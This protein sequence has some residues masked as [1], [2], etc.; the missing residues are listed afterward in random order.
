MH[1]P[2]IPMID[3][4]LVL[5]QREGAHLLA[6]DVLDTVLTNMDDDLALPA[7]RALSRLIELGL[8]PL[9]RTRASRFLNTVA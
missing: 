4:A 1:V 6:S 7:V 8:E 3:C 9:A 5:L 2:G